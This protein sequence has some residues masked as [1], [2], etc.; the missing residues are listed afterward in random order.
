MS[1]DNTEAPKEIKEEFVI[2]NDEQISSPP[3]ENC[4]LVKNCKTKFNFGNI[5]TTMGR[6]LL[7]T[8]SFNIL[9]Y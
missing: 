2:L 7:S 1:T 9:E 8:N 6:F 4:V 5:A 3:P